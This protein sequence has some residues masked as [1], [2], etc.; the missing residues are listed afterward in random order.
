M[1]GGFCVLAAIWAYFK[2]KEPS[3]TGFK[4][5]PDNPDNPDNL[6]NNNNNN[7]N[8]EIDN[9]PDKSEASGGDNTP[10][11]PNDPNNPN[12]DLKSGSVQIQKNNLYAIW[13]VALAF[14][15][16]MY[17]CTVMQTLWGLTVEDFFGWGIYTLFIH[18]L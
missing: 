3:D 13:T 8:P 16:S 11:D 18:Y 15:C 6:D 1:A 7:N 17:A 12:A 4:V 14:A 10:N 2:L 9:N 5:N